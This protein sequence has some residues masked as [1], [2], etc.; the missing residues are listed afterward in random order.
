MNQILLYQLGVWLMAADILWL[1]FYYFYATVEVYNLMEKGR[2]R[3][4]GSLWI[5]KKK[6]Q[7]YLQI[8]EEMTESSYTTEYKVVPGIF[9]CFINRGQK[10]RIN[11][12]G[13][14]EVFTEVTDPITVK[15]YIATYPRL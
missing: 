12:Q 4:M 13:K 6:G 3:Y 8:S 2:Y 1:L 10:I 14:Y 9:F 11:F 5:K 15:N 7:Y